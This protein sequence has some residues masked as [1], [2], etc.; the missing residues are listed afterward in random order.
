M[1]LLVLGCV[2]G[3]GSL[4]PK[5]LFVGGR[6]QLPRLKPCLPP[7]AYRLIMVSIF[8]CIAAVLAGIVSGKPDAIPMVFA[9]VWTGF[10]LVSTLCLK[11]FREP[12]AASLKP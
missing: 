3:M 10:L 4:L 9:A 2:I 7:L 1:H 5:E 12:Q 6:L 11:Y 8:G